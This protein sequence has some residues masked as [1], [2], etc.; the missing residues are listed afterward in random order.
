MEYQNENFSGIYDF[1]C[2][3]HDGWEMAKHIH[4]YSELLYCAR[5]S[6]VVCV[7]RKRIVLVEKQ[8]IWIPPNY[9]HEYE[10][11]DARLICAVFSN[12]FI[13]AYF[14]MA[15]GKRLIVSA[16]DAGELSAILE[17]LH[18]LDK[19]GVL[20]TTAYLNLI[21]AKVVEVSDFE[22]AKRGDGTLY[23][24]VISYIAEHFREDITLRELSAKF[25]Y[26]AKYLS[27]SLHTLTGIHFSKLLAM[28][29]IEY[30]KKLITGNPSYSISK[31]ALES[32]FS[33]INT[34]NR[35]F[36]ELTGMTPSEYRDNSSAAKSS[37]E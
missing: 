17:S 32:G 10:R 34:F 35:S 22:S 37:V 18:T 23:Q 27:H 24:K 5:G 30:A 15:K 6:C 12:D 16:I 29:R 9:I 26:N 7:N 28:Y 4:E 33:A 21:C 20:L 13:P 8:L 1:R 14:R 25:G 2:R 3:I 31:T 36:K 11:T 19:T